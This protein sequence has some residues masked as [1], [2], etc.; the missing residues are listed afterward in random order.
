LSDQEGDAL[1]D[2]SVIDRL[3]ATNARCEI[4]WD[5]SPLIFGSWCEEMLDAAPERHV[6]R[7]RTQLAALMDLRDGPSGSFRGCTTNPPLSLRAIKDDPEHWD[8]RIME[9]ASI[10]DDRRE[11]GIAWT[12]YKETIGSGAERFRPLWDASG[13]RYGY[14]SGQLDPRIL[15][16]AGAMMAQ[17]R[18][19]AAIAPNVMVKVPASAQGLEVL[20]SITSEGISTNV[21]TCFTVAQTLAA[22]RAVSRGVL[23]AQERGN[24]LGRWR[25]VITLMLARLTERHAL[26]HQADDIGLR[27]APSDLKWFGIAVVKKAYR[28]LEEGGFPSKLLVCS[29]RPGPLVAGRRRFWDIEKIAGADVVYTLP[30]SA[31]EALFSRDTE[32]DLRSDAIE[33]EVPSD[34]LRRVLQTPYG[35]QSYC[36]NGMSVEQFNTHPATEHTAAGFAK[37]ASD[38]ELYVARRLSSLGSSRSATRRSP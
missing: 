8:A 2:P 5:S 6:R 37:A 31:L 11:V 36:S 27:L 12:V 26:L 34:A 23:D 3:Q 35:L 16:D 21:T 28:L 30:P 4:W 15:A 14:V 29:V 25:S 10:G 17:A 32:L 20:R 24:S 38:L 19:I 7:L 33:E 9:L 1:R 13:G 22:A 18:E